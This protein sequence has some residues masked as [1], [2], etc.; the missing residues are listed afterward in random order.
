MNFTKGKVVQFYTDYINS[1]GLLGEGKLIKKI[2]GK[3]D[4][5]FIL[6]DQSSPTQEVWTSEKWKLEIIRL[7]PLG[8][9]FNFKIDQVVER[10][11][12]C[13]FGVGMANVSSFKHD[14]LKPSRQVDNFEGVPGWGQQF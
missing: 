5:T 10:E 3:S 1:E 9:S 8:V 12:K 2:R 13:L 7:T 11:L 4:F 6:E 14:N